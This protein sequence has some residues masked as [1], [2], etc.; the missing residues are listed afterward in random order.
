MQLHQHH[1]IDCVQDAASPLLASVSAS[2]FLSL[3]DQRMSAAVFKFNVQS[4]SMPF[5]CGCTLC[6]FLFSLSTPETHRRCP[7][8]CVLCSQVF[9]GYR[10]QPCT[11]PLNKIAEHAAGKRQN[12]S[13]P[14]LGWARAL[15][16]APTRWLPPSPTPPGEQGALIYITARLNGDSIFSQLLR[17]FSPVVAAAV[18]LAGRNPS[19][20]MRP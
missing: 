1:A 20:S 6:D 9:L 5:P 10:P 7:W 2:L 13:L 8:R 11:P 16:A 14:V 17:G 18:L 4:R 19:R 15:P 12:S 3:P